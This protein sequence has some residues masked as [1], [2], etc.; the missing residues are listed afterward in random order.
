ME[1]M[2]KDSE[3]E[4]GRIRSVLRS[5]MTWLFLVLGVGFMTC[6]IYLRYTANTFALEPLYWYLFV[7]HQAIS[8]PTIVLAMIAAL[9]A[10]SM[11]AKRNPESKLRL[12]WKVA[13]LFAIAFAG[14]IAIHGI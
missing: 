6:E 11:R 13:A 10:G 8:M 14:Y 3:P 1:S 4:E 9:L 5:S 12:L 2:H 7:E